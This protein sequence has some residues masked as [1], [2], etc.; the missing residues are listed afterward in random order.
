MIKGTSIT[1]GQ[2]LGVTNDG[3]TEQGVQLEWFLD[4]S[5]KY[6]SYEGSEVVIAADDLKSLQPVKQSIMP[7]GLQ[8]LMTVR[9]MR[10]LVSYL[11]SLGSHLD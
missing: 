1:G 11:E 4:G 2:G 7:H 9:E 3:V 5:L 6:I 10:E 8:E